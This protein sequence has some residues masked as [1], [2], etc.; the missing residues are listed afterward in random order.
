M[1]AEIIS[2]NEPSVA[3][4]GGAFGF[5]VIQRL[6]RE[7]HDF[8]N[9]ENG[10]LLFEVGAGQ[11]K[12]IT[13]LCKKTDL[14]DNINSLSDEDGVVRVLFMRKKIELYFVYG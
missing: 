11:G 5:S 2:S 4:D 12:M 6:I 14:Y 13:K 9:P 7:S 10:W 3:F 8:L 1:E